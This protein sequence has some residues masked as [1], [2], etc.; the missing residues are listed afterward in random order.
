[1]DRKVV[2]IQTS[3]D[4]VTGVICEDSDGRRYAYPCRAVISSMPLRD[5]IQ[6][7]DSAPTHVAAAARQLR[8][9]DFLTVGLKVEDPALFKDNWIYI[10]DPEV[11]VGRI[12]NFKNWSSEMVPDPN[13]SFVG[14]EYFCFEGDGLWRM[15]DE[16][17]IELGKKEI[18]Q[19]GLADRSK[20]TD[21]CVVRMPKAYPVYDTGYR[22]SVETIRAFLREFDNLW[23]AGRNGMHQYNN[24]DHSILSALVSARNILGTETRDPWMISHEAEYLED[25]A[26]PAP[27]D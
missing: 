3:A 24:Q 20:I 6:A 8:Y 10:H 14:L 5:L 19:I 13:V 2:E 22:Q 12:Q 11:S 18:E 9:R 7:I 17:L 1:M 21:A 15:P 16:K 23:S 26:V 4:H 25:R 27:V